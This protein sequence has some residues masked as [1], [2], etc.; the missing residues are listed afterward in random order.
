MRRKGNPFDSLS[1]ERFHWSDIPTAICFA[2]ALLALG[3]ILAVNLRPLYYLDIKWFKISETSGFNP[4][5][6]K[7]N[8]NALID[9]CSPFFRGDLVFP[10]LPASASGISHFAECK[11]IFNTIYIAGLISLI[12][13]AVS[14]FIKSRNEEIKYLRNCAIATVVLPAIVGLAALINFDALFLLFHKLVFNN[15]D[16]LFDPATD[17]VIMI[18]PEEFFLQCAVIIILVMLI[19]AGIALWIYLVKKKHHK[20][21]SL[22]PKKMNYYY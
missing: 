5:I 13:T 12:F 1:S 19:G 16:W 6:I 14:F 8:Y 18:L 22:L 2:V 9:Y 17:P 21:Q 3:L 4:V 7:E 15:N 20:T 10:S 11:V